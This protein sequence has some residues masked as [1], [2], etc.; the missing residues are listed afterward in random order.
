MYLAFRLLV[1]EARSGGRSMLAAPSKPSFL[2]RKRACFARRC[3]RPRCG[4]L[5]RCLRSRRYT[6]ASCSST[7]S[8]AARDAQI[9]FR[10]EGYRVVSAAR[11]SRRDGGDPAKPAAVPGRAHRPGDAGR[12][13]ARRADGRQRAAAEATE[14]ILMTAHST[15][16]NAPSMPC[17]AAPTTSSPSPSHA[18]ELA[19]L[20]GKALE[21]QRHRRRE[22]A[23]PRAGLAHLERAR[24]CSA[25]A[26]RCARCCEL[27][28]A[29]RADATPPCSSPA[30][31]APARSCVAR[32]LHERCEPRAPARSWPS[33][34]ARCPR[35]CSRASCSATRRARSPAPQ[36]RTLGL[37]ATADG[38]TLLPRRGRRAAAR[39][40]G[41]AA[42]RA[43]GAHG[44]AGRRDARRCRSTCASSP[45]P[46]ATSRPTCASGKFRQDLYY[47]LNVIRIELPPLRERA[48]GHRRCSPSASCRRFARELGKD[49]RGLHA[50]RAARA[51]ALRVSRQ[52]AR[53]REHDRAR[54]RARAARARS[55]SAICPR[56]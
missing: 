45:P 52:R 41:Q 34:A 1:R 6:R 14:V 29:G 55:A 23:A 13:G 25:R 18:A 44:A 17:A 27:V 26:R 53:A 56:R 8:R 4:S 3:A 15:V 11:V 43:A 42:A 50:R 32:A 10:R 22:R 39:A 9:L 54:G 16:E 30:R 28:D 40:A 2:P 51:R 12:L 21:K 37:F 38:G 7:T 31:A 19:A 49:V 48:R 33:T 46:T 47:R 35:R 24:S 20:V 5:L 36:R